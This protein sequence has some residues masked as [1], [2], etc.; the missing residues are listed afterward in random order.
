[1]DHESDETVDQYLEYCNAALVQ[2]LELVRVNYLDTGLFL[3]FPVYYDE[4]TKKTLLKCDLCGTFTVLGKKRS[5]GR[6]YNHRSSTGCIRR[7][8]RNHNLNRE[9][10]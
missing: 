8:K 5:I 1:M 4:T 2:P 6:I 10:S 7:Q 3:D 9:R